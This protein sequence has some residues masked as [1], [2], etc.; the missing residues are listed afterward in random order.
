ML[1]NKKDSGRSIVE[2]LG[3]LAIMGVITVMGISGYSQAIGRINRNKVVEDVTRLAQETR[4]LYAGKDNYTGLTTDV[5]R[6]VM[7]ATVLDN[8]YGG[9][10]TIAPTTISGA[11]S[12]KYFTISIANVSAADCTYFTTMAWMD[13]RSSS[14]GVLSGTAVATPAA[15][16]GTSNSVAITYQ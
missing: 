12:P 11:T 13:A 15:C 1:L 3:V 14:T 10:Y 9:A 8:P 5:I 7:G 4:G 16:T 2:M 6:N